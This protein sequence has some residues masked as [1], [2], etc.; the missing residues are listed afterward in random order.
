M[1]KK[2]KIILIVSM[3]LVLALAAYVNIYLLTN[4]GDTGDDTTPT[5]SFFVTYRADR[6]ET[7]SYEIQQLDEILAIEGEEYAQ[8]RADA[9]EQKLKL[10]SVSELELLLETLLKAQ[11]FEDAVVSISTTSDNINVIVDADELTRE[12]TAVIYNIIISEVSTTPDYIR[13]LP[14]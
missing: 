4:D 2:K 5:A 10:V 14:V 12:D 6:Q 11:G 1:S 3:V 8:A 9:M 13:I 7:R